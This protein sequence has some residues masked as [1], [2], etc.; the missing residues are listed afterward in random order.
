MT[1]LDIQQSDVSVPGVLRN[2]A[3]PVQTNDGPAIIGYV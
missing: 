2:T 3:G 1:S